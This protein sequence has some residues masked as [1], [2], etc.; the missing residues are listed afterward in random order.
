MNRFI[1][2]ALL[3]LAFSSCNL[4][5]CINKTYFLGTYEN[6]I[7]SVKDESENYSES[8]WDSKDDKM[9]GFVDDCYKAHKNA[10]SAE[11]KTLFWTKSIEYM[12]IRY[13]AEVISAIRDEDEI[14]E[15]EIS[16]EISKSIKDLNIK[17]LIKDTYGDDI[18]QSIDEF[19][20]QMEDWAEELKKWLR[21]N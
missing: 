20:N 21:S 5:P 17:K 4:E 19:I 16:E 18:E 15:V 6:F 3:A 10:M 14:S 9:R 11:D 13:K 7:E 8:D 1:V 12:L 2:L